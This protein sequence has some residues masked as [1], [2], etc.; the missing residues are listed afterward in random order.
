[1]LNLGGGGGVNKVHYGPCESGESVEKLLKF[2][3]IY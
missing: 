3:L 2:N 1:M